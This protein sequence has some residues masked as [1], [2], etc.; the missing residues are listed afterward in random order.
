MILGDDRYPMK[1][2]QE[3]IEELVRRIV[4]AVHPMSIILFGSAARGEMGQSSDIDI[5][6]VMPDGTHRRRTAQDLYTK[7]V[8]IGVSVD[9]I[10]A[11]PVDLEKH[12]DNR[13]LIYHNALRDG[14]VLYAA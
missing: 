8:G 9:I 7:I 11:T 1:Q 10:V 2:V 3:H 5:M 6:V 4:D 13:S 14:V 12:K